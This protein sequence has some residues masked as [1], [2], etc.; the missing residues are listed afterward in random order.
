MQEI[1]KKYYHF[2]ILDDISKILFIF[3]NADPYTCRLTTAYTDPFV[4][5]L[6]TGYI[7]LINLITVIDHFR[8]LL[9]LCFENESKCETFHIKLRSV[10]SFIFVQIKVIFIRMFSLIDSLWNRGTR[11]LGN[12]LFSYIILAIFSIVLLGNTMYSNGNIKMNCCCCC[13]LNS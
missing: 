2:D 11:E 10:C 4:H 8:V 5:G 1:N 7:H 6:Q 9:C 3:N 12:G 13:C